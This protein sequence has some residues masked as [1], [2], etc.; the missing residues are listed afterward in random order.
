[1]GGSAAVGSESEMSLTRIDLQFPGNPPRA[2]LNE[3]N[4]RFGSQ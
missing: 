4:R 2:I 1:M 3:H